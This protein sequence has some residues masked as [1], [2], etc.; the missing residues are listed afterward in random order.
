MVA[1]IN[2]GKSISKALNYNEQKVQ[3]GK[4]ELILSEGFVKDTDQ[5]TFYDKLHHFERLTSLN[6]KV[7]TNTLHVSLNFDAADKL[8]KDELQT[9]AQTYMDRIGFG[10]Q[11]FL[12]YQHHDAGHNHIHIVSTNIQANGSRIS[13]HN[14]GKNESEKARKGI[15]KEFDLVKADSKKQ[16]E[17]QAIKPV[18][19]QKVQYGKSE[20]KR[21]IS[22]VLDT[23]L[24]QYKFTSL[25][26]LNA[27]LKQYKVLADRG[28][29]DSR[30]YQRGGL[31]YRVLDDKGNKVGVPIKAS[32]IYSKPT[33]PN[34]EGKFEQ[35]AIDRQAL[36][37]RPKTL[38]D[39]YFLK[40]KQPNLPGMIDA[41]QK[42]GITVVLRQNANG[43]I[44][45][46]TYVDH[47]TKCV[48]NGSDL[49]K[50]YSSKGVQDRMTPVGIQQVP[51]SV[52]QKKAPAPPPRP[53]QS[54]ASL[55]EA[56]P[57]PFGN[58]LTDLLNRG[59]DQQPVSMD[60]LASLPIELSTT[61]KKKKKRKRLS[62]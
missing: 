3:Q 23:V 53:S 45:G 38:I 20:T 33:L 36:S 4:A 12:V 17:A 50:A 9:I 56:A 10:R 37:K 5:L 6:E 14:L 40:T 59:P 43:D 26:E 58:P 41:L 51:P 31:V 61:Q 52:Q 46:M 13:M 60:Q 55:P 48:F 19:A 57:L 49:G 54:P 24:K 15:E 28:T 21:A 27:I 18:N 35:N 42:E 34:L 16:K 44:Y 47:K 32:S 30:T 1:R 25:P 39:W 7:V 8:S 11:P 29:P 2:T 22:N 62:L